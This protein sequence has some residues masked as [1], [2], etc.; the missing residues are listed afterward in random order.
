[1]KR[2][3]AVIAAALGVL[4]LVLQASASTANQPPVK[5][6]GAITIQSWLEATP[7]A[8]GLSGTVEASFKL[9][10]V[11]ADQGGKPNWTDKTYA[12]FVKLESKCGDPQPVGGFLFTPPAAGSTLSTVYAVHTIAGTKGQ[13]FI[14]FSGTYDL[15]KTYTGSGTWVITGGTGAYSGLHGS[16]KWTADARKFPYIRHT[17]TGRVS[18]SH[19]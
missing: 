18:W 11:L 14:T 19:S 8:T 17:E 3:L 15:V 6:A 7:S 13:I 4:F 1:M 5:K 12:N 9:E 2:T 16:G 10:G